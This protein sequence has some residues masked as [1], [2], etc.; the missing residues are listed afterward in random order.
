[1][2]LAAA[3]KDHTILAVSLRD[4]IFDLLAKLAPFIRKLQLFFT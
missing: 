1:M 2:A 3:K 4:L